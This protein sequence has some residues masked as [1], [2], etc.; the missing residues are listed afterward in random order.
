MST[1]YL[2]SFSLKKNLY[3]EKSPIIIL[4]GAIQYDSYKG[5][6]FA[7]LKFKNISNKCITNLNIKLKVLDGETTNNS[8]EI[9]HSYNDVNA[10]TA[11]EF[12]QNDIIKLPF[13]NAKEFSIIGIEV[14]FEDGEIWSTANSWKSIRQKSISAILPDYYQQLAYINK[15]GNNAKYTMAETEEF[16]ICTCS[17]VLH[18]SESICPKC[19]A[20]RE[21]LKNIDREQLLQEGIWLFATKKV[22]SKRL[23]DLKA[24]KKAL[25]LAK[26]TPEIKELANRVGEDIRKKR[27]KRKK[28]TIITVSTA[29]P[30][31]V[32][33][34]LLLLT[35]LLFIPMSHYNA[36]ED[37]I[38]DGKYGEAYDEFLEAGDYDDAENMCDEV[39][40]TAQIA[41]ATLA[42][43]GEYFDAYKLLEHLVE[44]SN[45]N[46]GN[47]Y[48]IYK[49]MATADYAMAVNYGLVDIVIPEGVTKI[50][51][52]AFYEC[53]DLNS[54]VLPST[55]KEIGTEAFYKCSNLEFIVIP[56]RVSKIEKN[57]FYDCEYLT[58]Y[59]EAS[60]APSGWSSKWDVGCQSVVMGAKEVK[61]SFDSNGGKNIEDINSLQPIELPTP[62]RKNYEF[63]GWYTTE[64]FSFGTLVQNPYRASQDVTLYAKWE[65]KQN[66][67]SFDEAVEITDGDNKTVTVTSE[68]YYFEFTPQISGRY[69]FEAE[70]YGDVDATL[71]DSSKYFL[72]SNTSYGD[73]YMSYY[74]TAGNTYYF[75]VYT[76]DSSTYCDISL[77]S[78]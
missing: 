22:E 38:K 10:K 1:R 60:K 6:S 63:K 15:F 61:Y 33:T 4:G 54:I 24:A 29:L 40:E 14:I 8:F 67:S 42:E 55:L 23:S 13:N 74:M 34:T 11:A 66:G 5:I 26:E 18:A 12:A 77:R 3:C 46:I 59:C 51:P 17:N 62:T 47:E 21:D 28:A 35:F 69:I 48:F 56:K 57:A 78:Y 37:Y 25:D 27:V 9:E 70:A 53:R 75:A 36:G 52:K 76:Y 7:Q 19:K 2:K 64:D 41:A 32:I 68:K 43:A 39:I 73:V 65:S 45:V 72:T 49:G 71:Y 16:W 20:S 30:T 58:V 50:P 31:V 44:K